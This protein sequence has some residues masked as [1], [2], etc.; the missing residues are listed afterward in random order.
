MNSNSLIAIETRL[1]KL[2]RQVRNFK[3]ASILV[4]IGF[5]ATVAISNADTVTLSNDLSGSSRLTPERVPVVNNNVGPN[6]RVDLRL[7]KQNAQFGTLEVDKLIIKDES[8]RKTLLVLGRDTIN[9]VD[10]MDTTTVQSGVITVANNRFMDRKV[11]LDSEQVSVT[12]EGSSVVSVKSQNVLVKNRIGNN[13]LSSH[14]M[15]VAR[16]GKHLIRIGTT[17]SDGSMIN[18]KSTDRKYELKLQA[19]ENNAAIDI[20]NGQ[21][22]IRLGNGKE[23][24][25]GLLVKN[26]AKNTS[27]SVALD[28]DSTPAVILESN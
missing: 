26:K 6:D 21:S 15:S 18:L 13:S 28:K 11:S 19:E 5:A 4:P 17:G 22:G 24:S 16:N 12:S 27:L 7:K 2:E 10:G 1:Y 25:V 9:V 14:G 20:A 23:S 3:I 8:G